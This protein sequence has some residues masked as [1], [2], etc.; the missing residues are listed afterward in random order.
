MPREKAERPRAFDG[1][2]EGS[3]FSPNPRR[4][5]FLWHVFQKSQKQ[6]WVVWGVNGNQSHGFKSREN[7]T[8]NSVFPWEMFGNFGV[9]H[10]TVAYF[11][12]MC[13]HRLPV[14]SCL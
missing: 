1:T 10:K 2:L 3:E 6:H 4:F 7:L 8:N 11:E 5:I 14:L 9:C 13:K 12:N